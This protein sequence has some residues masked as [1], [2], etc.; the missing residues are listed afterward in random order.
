MTAISPPTGPIAGGQSVTITGQNFT[1]ATAVTIGGLSGDDRHGDCDDDH[2][3]HSGPHAAGQVDVVVTTPIGTGTGVKIYTYVS[4][5]TLVST[6]ATTLQVGKT[7]SQQNTASGGTPGYTYSVSG[8]SLPAGTSLSA[9]TGLVFGIPT[10]LGN[11]SYTITATDST[12]PAQ[13]AAQTVTGTIAG[14]ASQLALASSVNPS[15]WASRRRCT[16]TATPNSCTGTITFTDLTTRH[17]AVQ[18]GTDRE[19]VRHLHGQVRRHRGRIR[20]K[21]RIPAA[22]SACASVSPVLAQTVNDQTIKT[23]QTIGNFMS[24]RNDLIMSS[25]PDLN[26]QVDRLAEADGEFVGRQACRAG[27]RGGGSAARR[28]PRCPRPLTHA[29]RSARPAG[30]GIAGQLLLTNERARHS[31]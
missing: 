2:R 31:R 10:A 5:V 18:R 20:S 7:Y 25:E 1:G 6:P 30:S 24:R 3:N 21:R 15:L 8:G 14:I 22:H 28:R 4:V 16:A 17:R 12:V 19:W 26:R 27:V 23:T 13:T 9:S 29:V 11:F